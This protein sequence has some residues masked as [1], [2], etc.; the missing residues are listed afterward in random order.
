MDLFYRDIIRTLFQLLCSLLISVESLDSSVIS[1]IRK[2]DSYKKHLPIKT[3][4]FIHDVDNF[5]SVDII[6]ASE[7]T[8]S[9]LVKKLQSIDC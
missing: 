5:T 1:T 2:E 6:E 3:R 8:M 9:I 4:S 7:L